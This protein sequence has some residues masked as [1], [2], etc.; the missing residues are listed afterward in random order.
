MF[1][2]PQYW[3][4]MAL[5]VEQSMTIV[6]MLWQGSNKVVS[7]RQLGMEGGGPEFGLTMSRIIGR[8]L[9]SGELKQDPWKGGW[10]DGLDGLDRAER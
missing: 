8:W 9:T 10:L 1:V 4:E 7:L 5:G 2:L 3:D 6:G